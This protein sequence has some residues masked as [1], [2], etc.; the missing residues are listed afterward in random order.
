M[1]IISYTTVLLFVIQSLISAVVLIII[2][3]HCSSA[4]A[5]P[6]THTLTRSRSDDPGF[7][8]P[9]I[10][11]FVSVVQMFF[12]LIYNARSLSPSLF[13]VSS[14]L[15]YFCHFLILSLSLS[16]AIFLSLFIAIIVIVIICIIAMILDY[17][18]SDL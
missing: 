10:G 16:A 9:D 5:F 17:Y 3:A 11:R 14:S 8:R 13:L 18:D 15:L 4:R 2:Y 6:F 1:L 12:A 7:A